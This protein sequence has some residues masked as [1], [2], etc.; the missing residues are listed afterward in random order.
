VL[1]GAVSR[2]HV[3]EAAAYAVG[4]DP[5][6]QQ[7]YLLPISYEL[8]TDTTSPRMGGPGGVVDAYTKDEADALLA[9]KASTQDVAAIVGAA[10]AALDTLAEIA[11]QL[12]GDEVGAAAM[13]A[14]LQQHSLQLAT[15]GVQASPVMAYLESGEVAGYATLDEALADTRPKTFMR[16]NVAFLTL[17]KSNNPLNPGWA[18]YVDGAGATLLLGAGVVLSI[19]GSSL[20]TL[21]FKNFFIFQAPG[22]RGGRVKLLA[23]GNASTPPGLLPQL[24]GQCAVPLELGA[25]GSL[26]GTGTAHLFEPYDTGSV[27][28][29]VALIKHEVGAGGSGYTDEQAQAAAAAQL[30]AAQQNGVRITQ[31]AHTKQLTIEN[32]VLVYGRLYFNSPRPGTGNLVRSNFSLTPAEE[33]AYGWAGDSNVDRVELSSAGS[34]FSDTLAKFKAL[35]F[36]LLAGQ[37]YYIVLTPIDV[38]APASLTLKRL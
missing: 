5:Q 14:R 6:T 29:G 38:N 7:E 11:D 34:L 28:P 23:T 18:A 26:L 8:A 25:Y 9:T 37:E 27:G 17:T 3:A 15:L 19:P 20:G 4:L 16:F 1:V 36:S 32:T 21:L 13:L 31:D 24:D 10:P 22:T 35:N 2:Y 30:L 33:A 12:A